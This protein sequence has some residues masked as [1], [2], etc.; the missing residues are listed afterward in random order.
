VVFSILL[1]VPLFFVHLFSVVGFVFL[2]VF[3]SFFTVFFFF[4]VSHL[5]R[6]LSQLFSVATATGG[7]DPSDDSSPFLSRVSDDKHNG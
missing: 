6:A 5:V 7:D 4:A 1:F 3:L 2:F